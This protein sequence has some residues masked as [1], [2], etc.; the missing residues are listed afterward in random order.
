MFL[1]V[2]GSKFRDNTTNTGSGGIIACAR[3]ED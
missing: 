1:L 3:R 2:G